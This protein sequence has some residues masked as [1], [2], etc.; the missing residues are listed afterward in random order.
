MG[1]EEAIDL[2][3]K[4]FYEQRD[5]DKYSK[6]VRRVMRDLVEFCKKDVH[7]L[8]DSDV[9]RFVVSKDMDGSGRTIVHS[10]DCEHLGREDLNCEPSVKCGKR[11]A[12]DSLRSG[13]I[14]KLKT[15]FRDLGYV[16]VWN[17]RTKEGNPADSK[18]VQDYFDFVKK[19]QGRAGVT[20]KQA[21]PILRE[22]L[23]LVQDYFDFVKKEQGRAGVTV[24]QAVPILREKLRKLISHMRSRRL[25]GNFKK[26]KNLRNIALYCLV[27]AVAKRIDDATNV[28]AKNVLDIPNGGGLLFNFTWG[29]TLRSGKNHMFGVECSCNDYG[30]LCAV[31]RI[32][33]YVEK[34]K[35]CGWDFLEGYLFSDMTLKRE[36]GVAFIVRLP[37]KLET[38]KV[39]ADFRSDL[40]EA[41]LYA[42]ETAQSFR[43]G[44]AISQVQ[45]GKHLSEVMYKAYWRNPKTAMHYIK[46]LEVLCPRDVNWEAF[47][48]AGIPCA[49]YNEMNNMPLNLALEKWRAF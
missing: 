44:G 24:K 30:V 31:C 33:E 38:W 12:S 46:L 15:G 13:Y 32:G 14:S 37:K 29:K 9:L 8:G 19:E 21:V 48:H 43:A 36:N 35:A 28:V 42:K 6:D 22:K 11:H 20:V 1:L 47:E 4:Y 7:S 5:G 39:A 23:K 10:I 25:K 27:F 34:A 17:P 49:T 45:E 3:L 40:E 2:R 16:S 26:L 41:G 18:L